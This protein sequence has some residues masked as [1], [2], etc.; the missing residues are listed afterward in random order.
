MGREQ[1]AHAE[2]GTRA[3]RS[4]PHFPHVMNAK[5]PSHGPIFRSARMGMLAT[6]AIV[7]STYL[8]VWVKSYCK[9]IYK[10]INV[11]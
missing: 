6:Q 10:L 2:N 8:L 11:G 7:S 4:T 3:K 1:K 5:T 9:V